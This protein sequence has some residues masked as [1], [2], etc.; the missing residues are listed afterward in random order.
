MKK[1][2]IIQARMGSSRLPGKVLKDLQGRSVLQWV[3][4][5][6]N[7]INGIDSI[8]VATSTEQQDN[9]IEEWCQAQ[10]ISIFRGDEKNVLER[11][12]QA[13]QQNNAEPGDVIMRLTADC[14]LLDPQVCGE[15]LQ[16]F[17]RAGKDYVNNI[18][19][20]RAWPDG[21]DCE[22]FTF[23][24]LEKSYEEADDELY[25]EHVTLYI[26]RHPELFSCLSLSCPVAGIGEYRW[27]LDTAD[28]F[29]HITILTDRLNASS[30]PYSYL[31]ILQ[32][33]K[34]DEDRSIGNLHGLEQSLIHL[35]KALQ[36][37]PGASQTF[38]KSYI[39]HIEGISPFFIERGKGPYVWD[40]DGNRYL[41]YLSALLPVLLG[42]GD[43]D[44]DEAIKAQL[45]KGI[46]F[47]LA[48]RLETEL[49][50]MLIDIIPCAEMVRF[51]KNGS[52]V[53]AGAIRLAR[54]YT[55]RTQI[56]ICGYHGWHDWYIGTTSQDKGVPEETKALADT[57]SFN[58]IDSLKALL[59]HKN[60]AAII[61]EAEGIETSRD[62]FLEDVR[63]L[64]TEHG[65]VLIFDEIVS[66][67]RSALGG[68]QELR[69]VEPDLACFG[70]AMGNGMPISALVGKKDVMQ[71][72][73][74]VF[75]SG[76][77][78]GET[79][80]MA[81]ALACLKKYKT[82][83]GV[84]IIH[85]LGASLK[86]EIN[87]MFKDVGIENVISIKGEDWW[88]I[89]GITHDDSATLKMLIRQELARNGIIQGNS[90]NLMTAH[91]DDVVYN[92]TLESWHNV[93][94][95]LESILSSKNPV[96][97]FLVSEKKQLQFQVRK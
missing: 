6:A 67:F 8:I 39:Q 33:E 37:T 42:Y 73:D 22:V 95:A 81:A 63:T 47:S 20:P 51:A 90:F 35:P 56:A 74:Q 17:I 87:T 64:A 12:Y 96:K 19:N 3:I 53:T 62:G 54:A 92:Q 80:S 84:E 29:E 15:V 52:D 48:T 38:S 55:E 93:A 9:E 13:A 68:V 89:I 23:N 25:K 30:A 40:I 46:S 65:A 61:I 75:F 31:D 14:P 77:F 72:L 18:G 41:D 21:L 76:T 78:G 86:H 66:G 27:T 2:A 10:N 70:K 71:V 5:A 16:L 60:Y 24:A 7:A 32:V 1:I 85:G 79:L 97:S 94:Q 11:Y 4:D 59:A 82:I 83:N 91:M 57:F 49:A 69:G 34:Q 26:R 58:N 43:D 44:V 45:A 28:D 50:T 36:V 88:P